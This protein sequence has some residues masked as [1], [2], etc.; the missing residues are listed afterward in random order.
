VK[1]RQV[2]APFYGFLRSTSD[3]GVEVV[4]MKWGEDKVTEQSL[5]K[6]MD[7]D[8]RLVSG[9][10]PEGWYPPVLCVYTK[11]KGKSIQMIYVFHKDRGAGRKPLTEDQEF[12][13]F[14]LYTN[15]KA[16][17]KASTESPTNHVNLAVVENIVE[18][19]VLPN[20]VTWIAKCADNI[21]W[22]VTLHLKE[23]SAA[24]YEGNPPRSSYVA[25]VFQR[26]LV[27]DG[28]DLFEYKIDQNRTSL[29]GQHE[30][31]SMFGDGAFYYPLP[32]QRRREGGLL[33]GGEM[34]VVYHAWVPPHGPSKPDTIS[35]ASAATPMRVLAMHET[36]D[37]VRIL[38]RSIGPGGGSIRLST[39][40]FAVRGR[41]WGDNQ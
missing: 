24:R 6:C 23:C 12:E 20:G 30:H 10:T 29:Q 33:L 32:V 27:D 14:R 37:Q 35:V 40:Q 8:G 39:R 5:G 1:P 17:L 25:K 7:K 41:F 21:W 28:A 38:W 22:T 18:P 9:A 11:E 31:K 34:D 26:F 16:S 15:L 4:V 13:E 19:S 36:I 3:G 2:E